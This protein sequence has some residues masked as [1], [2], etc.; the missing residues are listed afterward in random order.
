MFGIMSPAADCPTSWSCSSLPCFRISC[1]M[2]PIQR[3]TRFVIV[4]LRSRHADLDLLLDRCLIQIAQP[5]M[6]SSVLIRWCSDSRMVLP[7]RY[8][9][10]AVAITSL[11]TRISTDASPITHPRTLQLRSISSLQLLN[12]PVVQV[13]HLYYIGM[14]VSTKVL[15]PQIRE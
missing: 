5:R 10:I 7:E 1:M 13:M 9:A 11:P 12:I 15:E 8:M 2:L 6:A 3:P 14:H 4:Y